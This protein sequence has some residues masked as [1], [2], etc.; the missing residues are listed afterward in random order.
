[1]SLIPTLRINL[2]GR[3]QDEKNVRL[4]L[5]LKVSGHKEKRMSTGLSVP[6]RSYHNGSVVGRTALVLNII[7]QM[8]VLKK[9]LTD[10]YWD[11][12]KDGKNPSPE[13]IISNIHNNR[14]TEHTVSKLFDVLISQKVS[15]VKSGDASKSL[16]E[17]FKALKADFMDFIKLQYNAN[18]YFLSKI[19]KNVIFDF[20]V[21]LKGSEKGNANV[22]V[23][24]KISNL[25][26]LFVYAI[27]NDWMKKNP[28]VSWTPFSEPKTNNEYLSLEQFQEVL[29]FTLPNKS[30]EVV[31]DTFIFM[32][33]T[34]MAYSDMVSFSYDQIKIMGDRK[35]ISYSR[36]KLQR[37]HEKDVLV[38]VVIPAMNII[39]K[40]F[41]E[42]K[43]IGRRDKVIKTVKDKV[44]PVQ[45]NQIYNQKIKKL[46]EA[47]EMELEFII[48]SHAG[49]KTFGNL[50][51]RLIGMSDA[52]Q[53]LGHSS[54][55][56]T[57]S[58]YVD[59]QAHKLVMER[60]DKMAIGFNHMKNE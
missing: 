31:K 37:H 28:L 48:S 17:K 8:D 33:F 21:Y 38:P 32:C 20:S 25:N 42:P 35:I 49:R 56:I 39:M 3:P 1:M 7:A 36:T 10:S 19:N 12:I 2:W 43:L 52:S 9:M 29:K 45:T 16:E 22:T 50:V 59:N 4:Y 60:F 41:H 15:L 30:Y 47:N 27:E 44:F 14:E 5:I 11:L 34:G 40:Y 53:M 57:E 46:F 6:I 24:K 51:N 55:R 58:N 18:D 23:N 13:L 26:Q 54:T